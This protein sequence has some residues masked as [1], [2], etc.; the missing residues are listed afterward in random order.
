MLCKAATTGFSRQ[1]KSE[2]HEA[3]KF[4]ADMFTTHAV[5]LNGPATWYICF[6]NTTQIWIVTCQWWHHEMLAVFSGHQSN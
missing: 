1:V 2:E 3:Q 4:Y 5:L 6:R